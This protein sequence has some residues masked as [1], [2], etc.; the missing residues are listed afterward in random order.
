VKK[1]FLA[2][3]PSRSRVGEFNPRRK[4]K[5]GVETR[6]SETNAFSSQETSESY[7]HAFHFS[8]IATQQKIAL[9]GKIKEK[10]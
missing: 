5:T 6:V 2:P 3:A 4:I 7:A 10:K 9:S 8:M 1:E